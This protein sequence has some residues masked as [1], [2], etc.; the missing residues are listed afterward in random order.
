MMNSTGHL[1]AGQPMQGN[2]DMG[3]PRMSGGPGGQGHLG[4]GHLGQ[5][6]GPRRGR[7]HHNHY[8]PGAHHHH[9]QYHQPHVAHNPMYAAN[10]MPQPYGVPPGYYAPPAYQNAAMPNPY[11]MPQYAPPAATYARSPPAMQHY[12]PM[13]AQNP[14]A[15]PAPPQSPIVSTPY[16]APP[17]AT[18]ALVP[19]PAP[20]TPSSTHSHVVPTPMTPPA[21]QMPPIVPPQPQ[22]QSQ[23]QVQVQPE[24]E[25]EIRQKV[26][27]EPVIEEDKQPAQ[28]EVDY[29][30]FAS[31]QWSDKP[32]FSLPWYSHPDAPFPTRT[33]LKRRRQAPS[34]ASENVSLPT[35]PGQQPASETVQAAPAETTST[36]NV[37]EDASVLTPKGTPKLEVLPPRSETPSTQELPS[38]DTPSTSPT[39][40]VPSQQFQVSESIATSPSQPPKQAARAPVPAVP[41]VPVVPVLPKPALKDKP[42]TSAEK[43][44]AESKP[45]GSA[46]AVE[47]TSETAAKDVTA[48]TPD[49]S[50]SAEQAA[51]A[52]APAPVKPKS[53]A[54]LFTKP[55]APVN[56]AAAVA[57]AA[58]A[59]AAQ[60]T[61]NG[62][63]AADAAG[64][65][66]GVVPG[67]AQPKANSMAEA[68]QSYRVGTAEKIAFLE[69][70]GLVN[71][72]NMC[73]MNSILQ[74]LVNCIPFYDFLDQVSKKAVHSFNSETPLLDAMIMFMRE[75]KVIDSAVSIDQLKRRLKNEELEQYGEAFTPE[76]VYDAIRKLPRFA[77]M[78]R[79]H[80]QDA[81]EFLGFLLEG[82]HDECT[83]VMRT[84]PVSTAST[85][86]NSSL[87]SP[88]TSNPGDDWLEVGP[89]QKAAV[90]R[91]SGYSSSVSPITKIF[92]G[93]LR[94]ELRIPG[95]KSSVTLEPYQPLQLDIGA[96][97]VRNIVDALRGLT[98]PETIHGDFNSPH[99]KDAK[100]TKQ[101]FIES[102]PPV[103][104]LH[105]KRFQFDAE[106]H[107]TIKIWKKVGYPLE[108]EIPREV[109]SRQK[110][111]TIHAE[112]AD[113]LKY[114]LITVVYHHGKNASGGHYTVDVR[115][116]D[117]REWVRIDDTVIRRVRPEDV[118]EG[119][120][121]EKPSKGA[122]G[123][124][125][126]NGSSAVSNRF[127]AM[128][129]D[130]TGDDEGWKQA[131]ANGKK[132]S[133]VVNGAGLAAPSGSGSL[134][135]ASK[136]H[137][138]GF[139]DNKVA[140]LLFYQRI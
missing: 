56:T 108:L 37:Q 16:Q 86:P 47:Q 78:R 121:E 36:E 74:V 85:A 7:P 63:V 114:R 19:V 18:P 11:G 95:L 101:V 138:D 2:A 131:T 31:P 66:A 33:K 39:S 139:K 94:S 96:P 8:N 130:D 22:I 93:Q 4:Q 42:T 35:A 28:A 76:F 49:S 43:P 73:Y 116:Q 54:N 24:P 34:A 102:L 97:E 23:P 48:S 30:H 91:T 51:P 72:G 60:T 137:N 109:V 133:S 26:I 90:T 84:L 99:G 27:E 115:R 1:P 69:P 75:F 122:V 53:W 124:R 41:A 127:S 40:S 88:T 83:H 105:L 125:K 112:N 68:V 14:Y 134:K 32:P 45:A 113:L 128:N 67:F 129:D 80:Q 59:A 55:A 132:W 81:E 70:R 9:G 50:T 12:M 120:A 21:Q 92:G 57:A 103:L 77:S 118:A 10:Y 58:A 79:G 17:M 65:T 117:G 123:D 87:P 46:P 140:Y 62:H 61:V 71:T 44:F 135:A 110:R 20:H 52:P 136:Q 64:V 13:V 106:G 89:R 6:H 82:L 100:A 38:V 111:N 15:R 107:G 5:G 98:R 25:P 29:S 104:I 119:G 3:I 126:E